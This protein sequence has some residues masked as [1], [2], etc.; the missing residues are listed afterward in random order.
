MTRVRVGSRK[1]FSFTNGAQVSSKDLS[2]IPRAVEQS[3]SEKPVHEE[4]AVEEAPEA[5]AET[6]KP[7]ESTLNVSSELPIAG[8]E[9]E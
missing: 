6:I 4:P 5:L 9:C 2:H 7:P 1:V 3:T 8:A